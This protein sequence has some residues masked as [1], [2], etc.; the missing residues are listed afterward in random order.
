MTPVYTYL[1]SDLLTNRTLAEVPLTGVR[2][3]KKLGDVGQL[4]ANLHLGDPRVQNLEPY[5]L[6]TP[7]RRVIY[8]LRDSTP[9][10]GGLIWTRRYE[11]SSAQISLGCADFWSY[12]DHRKVLPVLAEQAY[13]DPHYVA[14]RQVFWSMDQNAIA[15]NLIT[16]AQSHRAGDIGITFPPGSGDS[17]IRLERTY[18]G[19]Q[20]ANTGDALR[21]LSQLLDGPDMMFDVGPVDRNGRPARWLRLGTPRLG[22]VG[23]A[24]VW[25]YGGNLL[26]YTWPSDGTRMATRTFA[27]GDGIEAGMLIGVAEDKSRYDDGWPLLETEYG[28]SSVTDPVQ[29][30]S[31]AESDQ[32]VSRLPVVLP[33]LSVHGALPPTVAEI[34]MGDDARVIIKDAF[35]VNGIDTLMRIVGLDVAVGDDG[36]ESVTLTMN[37]LLEDVT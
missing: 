37:P 20:N 35:H 26:S 4:S 14:K 17:A 22:Q 1:I 3:S 29:L 15:R 10:W 8:V 27:T 31:H 19:Y 34:G 2:Y 9:V 30:K 7:A 21:K 6:T 11:S 5:E 25:E 23:S 33:T 13:T 24:H 28:Y 36:R 18:F 12:F 32:Q 16:L